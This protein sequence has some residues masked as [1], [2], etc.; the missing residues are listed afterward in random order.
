MSEIAKREAWLLEVDGKIVWV[1]GL[2]S[3]D[4]FRVG[5]RDKEYVRLTYKK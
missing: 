4:V 5:S 2:R 1:L 3:A